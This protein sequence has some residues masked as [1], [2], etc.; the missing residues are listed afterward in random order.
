MLGVQ[1]A[2]AAPLV[3]GA[4]GDEP[5][6]HR[7]RDPHRLAGVLDAGRRGAED[8]GGHFLA[9]TDEEILAAYHLVARTEGVF[10]EPASAASVAGLLKSVE[11]GWVARRFDGGVHRDRQRAQGPRHRAEGHARG[12]R[13][14]RRRGRGGR[15]NWDWPSGPGV[16]DRVDG[17][18][19]GGG[20]ERQ[21]GSRVRLSGPGA[22]PLRRGDRRDGRVRS[23]GAGRG[24]GCRPGATDFGSPGGPRHQARTARSRGAG[25]R[26]G[27]ALP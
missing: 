21:P 13:C 7:H 5:G 4:A 2:G 6:D 16:A 17:Q 12:D 26:V 23:G 15:S 20:V 24:R 3:H 8:S 22:G 14:S 25:A 27:G 10:V 18:R 11:D 1:A 19:C 9:A